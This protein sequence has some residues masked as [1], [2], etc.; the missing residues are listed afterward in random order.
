MKKHGTGVGIFGFGRKKGENI[1]LDALSKQIK[2]E[3][4]VIGSHQGE[5]NL[6][7]LYGGIDKIVKDESK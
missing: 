2:G 4:V 6:K 1:L 3:M 5:S 7:A